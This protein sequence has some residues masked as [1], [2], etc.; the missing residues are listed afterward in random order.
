MYTNTNIFWR[1]IEA[2][3][4]GSLW[5]I[6]NGFIKLILRQCFQNVYRVTVEE[7]NTINLG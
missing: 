2:A 4:N 6:L 5:V 7:K 3:S 1:V